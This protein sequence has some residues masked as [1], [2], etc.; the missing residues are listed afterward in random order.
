VK[1]GIPRMK[2]C[3][4]DRQQP[5]RGGAAAVELAL[6]LPFLALMFAV[7][8]DYCRVFYVTQTVQNCA[9]VAAMYA[10][11]TSSN[12]SAA[13]QEVAAQQAAVTEASTLQP[14]LDASMVTIS[15]QGSTAVVT[16]QYQFQALTPLMGNWGTMTISRTVTMA[17]APTGP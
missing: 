11:G 16:V 7:A 15:Y 5:R 17:M 4:R 14:P 12:P 10:S 13:S 3:L 8:V 9:W 6:A 2:V 1:G